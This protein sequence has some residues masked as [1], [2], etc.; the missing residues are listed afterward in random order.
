M[1]LLNIAVETTGLTSLSGHASWK[2]RGKYTHSI[3]YTY[4]HLKDN[5][6]VIPRLPSIAIAVWHHDSGGGLPATAMVCI[7]HKTITARNDPKWS[8]DH[9]HWEDPEEWTCRIA[10]HN[11]LSILVLTNT[12]LRLKNETEDAQ[13]WNS[14]YSH[15][16][17]MRRRY[18]IPL[19]A[20]CSNSSTITSNQRLRV[21]WSGN[22]AYKLLCIG[23]DNMWRC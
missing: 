3:K 19:F 23:S 21:W 16:L 18:S 1:P 5:N 20:T 22:K 15:F 6:L 4:K 12:N 10:N 14:Y 2:T 11:I 8:H 13:I 17:T 9:N 7:L